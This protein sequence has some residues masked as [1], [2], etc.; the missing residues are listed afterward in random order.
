VPNNAVSINIFVIGLIGFLEK[1]NI[2]MRGS[3]T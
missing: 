3:G 1:G 2:N